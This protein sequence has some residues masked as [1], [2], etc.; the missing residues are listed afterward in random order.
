M[1]RLT[2]LLP[3]WLN[4]RRAEASPPRAIY[5][6]MR[7]W[8][9]RCPGRAWRTCTRISKTTE[10]GKGFGLDHINPSSSV[11]A[12]Q[13]SQGTVHRHR[14]GFRGKPTE[15]LSASH[16][17]LVQR[18]KKQARCTAQLSQQ[19]RFHRSFRGSE[20]HW[21]SNGSQSTMRTSFLELPREVLRPRG[22]GT[23]FMV[24]LAAKGRRQAAASPLLDLAR[25]NEQVEHD[26][27]WEKVHFPLRLL[28]CCCSNGG[29]LLSEADHCATY[30][31][32]A[33]GIILPVASGKTHAG[34]FA[35]DRGLQVPKHAS[36]ECG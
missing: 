24:V 33:L 20:G 28:V 18:P 35:R 8:R 10:K 13:G 9:S 15:N 17:H 19:S 4:K 1:N 32:W 25:F 22:L 31:F 30:S 29:C 23:L 7:C 14:V 2:A 11:A 6:N 21:R 27:L 5:D 3:L 16:T 26:H 34:G 12:F 36:W